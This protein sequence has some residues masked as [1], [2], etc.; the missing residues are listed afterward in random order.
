MR[1]IPV[2]KASNAC[3]PTVAPLALAALLLFSSALEAEEPAAGKSRLPG[4]SLELV[5]GPSIGGP[6]GDLEAAM[7]GAGFDGSIHA[8]FFGCTTISYPATYSGAWD[9]RWSYW[10]AVR[11][12]LGRGPWH[13]GLGGGPTGFGT[14]VGYRERTSDGGPSAFLDVKAEVATLAPMAWF[15][16]ARGLRLGA[17][18]ALHR[19]D[20]DAAGAWEPDRSRSWKPGLVVEA[21][22]TVP[23]GTPVYFAAVVQYRLS[24]DVTTPHWETT[25]STGARL[26]FPSTSLRVSHGF[27]ALGIGGRF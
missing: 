25:T 15:E 20:L 14:V 19:I 27:V 24:A 8:C 10:G 5:A 3:P 9:E 18:P 23:A 13:V 26:E 2:R 22:L 4:W 6:L 17:G 1:S 21:A 7:R 16:P 12:R 11:H